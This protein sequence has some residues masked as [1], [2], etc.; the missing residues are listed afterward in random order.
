MAA[1]EP[2]TTLQPSWAVAAQDRFPGAPGSSFSK[3]S[4]HQKNNNFFLVKYP[5]FSGLAG[6]WSKKE[7]TPQLGKLDAGLT[8]NSTEMPRGGAIAG[9]KEVRLPDW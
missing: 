9:R 7:K 4:R 3:E 8:E 1:E 5:D 6:N 2:H